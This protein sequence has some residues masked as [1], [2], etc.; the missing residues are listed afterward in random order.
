M[1]C[2]PPLSSLPGSFA[3]RYNLISTELRAMPE[4]TRAGTLTVPAEVSALIILAAHLH[5]IRK[6]HVLPP[7]GYVHPARVPDAIAAVPPIP[8]VMVE[9]NTVQSGERELGRMLAASC[10]GTCCMI[11][12]GGTVR[13]SVQHD[14]PPRAHP[15]P[16]RGPIAEKPTR[17]SASPRA[18]STT[19]A[20]TSTA[21]GCACRRS[22]PVPPRGTSRPSPRPSALAP[23][24]RPSQP[25]P[26]SSPRSAPPSSPRS[27]SA[28]AC[29]P[30]PSLW[31]LPSRSR[32][33]CTACTATRSYA[34]SASA[35]TRA[36]STLPPLRPTCSYSH[37]P[38]PTHARLRARHSARGTYR[39]ADGAA[40]R[41]VQASRRARCPSDDEWSAWL[42]CVFD[43]RHL[44][45][46][47][48]RFEDILR[49]SQES[50]SE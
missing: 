42:C 28:A 49:T 43:G 20:A 34:S 36:P 21:T 1:P 17:S 32:T 15:P 19:W 48:R 10:R 6:L 22:Y 40:L 9:H 23:R 39:P 31:A 4:D 45:L 24:R 30:A 25:S 11:V 41:G 3:P 33:S 12:T 5:P 38:R 16:A 7:S 14:L 18:S 50:D 35:R 2:L 37:S 27:P 13:V 47:G 46:A 44:F 26:R 8:D 29:T